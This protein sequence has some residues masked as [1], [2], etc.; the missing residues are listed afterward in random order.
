MNPLNVNQRGPTPY[1]VNSIG[2][3]E[4]VTTDGTAFEVKPAWSWLYNPR[5]ELVS[6]NDTTTNDHDF[7]YIY[8]TIG[9]RIHTGDKYSITDGVESVTNSVNYS[10]NSLNQYTVIPQAPTAPEYDFDGNMTSGPLPKYPTVAST[11][12]WDAENRLVQTQVGTT[13]PVVHYAY[14]AQFRRIAKTTSTGSGSNAVTSA[15]LFVHDGFNCIAEY[16]AGTNTS[17]ALSKTYLWGIDLSGSL[18]GAGGVGGLLSVS[19]GSASN[20]PTFDGNGNVSEYL[21]PASAVFAHFEYDPFGNAVVNTDTTEQFPYRFSTKPLDSETGFYYYTYRYYDPATG[22]WLSRDPIG[23]NGG[24]NLYGFVGNDGIVRI[25]KNGNEYGCAGDDDVGNKKMVLTG[26]GRSISTTT[27]KP[28]DDHIQSGRDM[29][30]NSNNMGYVAAN[31]E[32]AVAIGTAANTATRVASSASTAAQDYA[33]AKGSPLGNPGNAFDQAKNIGIAGS[34][35]D[36]AYVRTPAVVYF[37]YRC[38]TC[39]CH[40]GS[41]GGSSYAWGCDGDKIRAYVIDN[42]D[43]QIYSIADAGL[44]NF[45]RGYN[46]ITFTD[47]KNAYKM[48]LGDN[49]CGVK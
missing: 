49:V 14:D 24:V 45:T 33:G 36:S 18:Q 6:A 19:Y 10:A 44:P 48:F 2:Q 40:S 15:T 29:A 32:G 5:G 12:V 38:C 20:F 26:Y 8:D 30:T 3:R 28:I 43:D 22:R 34:S 27:G 23:E 21:S 35:P 37:K 9:N 41:S 4:S 39:Q 13:G 31:V 17:A 16:N 1:T 25:D 46:D 11:L 47:I 7:G 42:D